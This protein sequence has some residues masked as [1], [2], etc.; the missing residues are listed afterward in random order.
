VLVALRSER[1]IDERRRRDAAD[2]ELADAR[3]ISVHVILAG[4]RQNPPGTAWWQV[5]IRN[6]SPSVITG[7]RLKELKIDGQLVPNWAVDDTS[8]IYA[9]HQRSKTR[10]VAWLDPHAAVQW[11]VWCHDA[12]G[13]NVSFPDGELEA[14]ARFVRDGWTWTRSNL[15]AP[16]KLPMEV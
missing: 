11:V 13:M 2:A 6:D 15:N 16:Q 7:I 4:H 14:T 9:G 8:G 12:E 3:L 10:D 5:T 1:K